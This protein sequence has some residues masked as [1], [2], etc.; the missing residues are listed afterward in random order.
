MRLAAA[1]TEAHGAELAGR[2]GASLH[3][4]RRREHVSGSLRCVE[5]LELSPRGILIPRITAEGRERIWRECHEVLECDPPR[6]V[7]D[8]RIESA[9]FVNNEHGWQLACGVRR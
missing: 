3:V 7:F 9:V 2:I 4:V 1:P 5:F 6:D 8:V